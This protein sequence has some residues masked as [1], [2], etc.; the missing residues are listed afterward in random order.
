MLG[1]QLF[2][3]SG[4]DQQI[5][6]LSP[7]AFGTVYETDEHGHAN[8]K[9]LIKQNLHRSFL[10]YSQAPGRHLVLSDG[11]YRP[12]VGRIEDLRLVNA[13]VELGGFGYWRSLYDAPYT[14]LWRDTTYKPWEEVTDDDANG[15]SPE[16]WQMDN[17]NRLYFAMREGE[18]YVDV[19]DKGGQFYEAPHNGERDIAVLSFDYDFTLPT[20][21]KVRIVSYASGWSSGVVEDDSTLVGDGSN[22]TG[23]HSETIT[24]GKQIVQIDVGNVT[25]G[26]VDYAGDTGDNYVK[27][28]NIVVKTTASANLYADEIAEDLAAFINGINSGQLSAV[29]ALIESPN[30]A[31][32]NELYEDELPA[33]ILLDL[34]ER[35]DD[36]TP[37]KRY[38]VGVWDG[39]MVRVV[40]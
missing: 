35:G 18:N 8:L 39:M 36:S 38:E 3:D 23:S 4:E 20:N 32:I 5:L 16:K 34:A 13:G 24:A 40:T 21:W 28:T 12:F 9:T 11:G 14:A 37:P 17:N 6:D 26:D 10:L 31:L 2:E 19:V 30:L 29:T 27:I 33:Q 7:F 1:L 22:Q 15:R 25:G